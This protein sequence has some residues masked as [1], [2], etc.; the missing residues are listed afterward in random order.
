MPTMGYGD[1][2]RLIRRDLGMTVETFAASINAKPSTV[3]RHEAMRDA[4]ERNTYG[5]ANS[6]E[7]RHG[8][9]WPGGLAHWVLKGHALGECPSTCPECAARDSNPEPAGK[10]TVITMRRT[11]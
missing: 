7:L 10:G 6:I 1:R 5:L 3:G 4:P 8:N 11:A 2:I 9:R